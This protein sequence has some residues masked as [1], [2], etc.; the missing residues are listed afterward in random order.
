MSEE[1]IPHTTES[2]PAQTPPAQ[3]VSTIPVSTLA[4]VSQSSLGIPVAIVIAAALIA[5]AIY[6]SG[7]QSASTALDIQKGIDAAQNPQTAQ[8]V[9]APAVTAKDM[10]RGNP[11]AAI[12]IVVYSD[13]DCPFCKIFH[14]TM[15]KIMGDYGKAGQVA[16]IYRDFPIAQLH[17]NAP[18]LAAAGK[19]VNAQGGNDAFWKFTDALFVS[20]KPVTLENGQQNIS[21]VDIT[22]LHEFAVQSGVDGTKFDTCLSSGTFDAAVQADVAAA[23]KVGAQGT[24][25]S[26][27]MFGNQQGVIN[28][29]QPY[30]V[31]KKAIDTILAQGKTN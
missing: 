11:N 18:K 10:I 6:M 5:G 27:V 15:L 4:K 20:R 14:D 3:T 22:K 2:I 9:N 17:P 29:A 19:C 24:P 26:V 21:F 30:E 28:G 12:K 16:W 23:A 7:K 31:V 8:N 13:F 25:Y 1:N